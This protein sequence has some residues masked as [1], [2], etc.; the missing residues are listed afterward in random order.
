MPCFPATRWR[1]S[2]MNL[3]IATYTQLQN[4]YLGFSLK[5]RETG[6][7]AIKFNGFADIIQTPGS[8]DHKY[9][10]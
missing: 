6:E 5:C 10:M 4:V 7:I 3:P 1:S 9:V 2:Y 8:K